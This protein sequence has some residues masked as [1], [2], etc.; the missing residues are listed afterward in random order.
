MDEKERR[1]SNPEAKVRAGVKELG[2]TVAGSQQVG[3]FPV[4]PLQSVPSTTYSHIPYP[5]PFQQGIH[6]AMENYSI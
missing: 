2:R 6:S 4:A 3:Q 1:V 5:A